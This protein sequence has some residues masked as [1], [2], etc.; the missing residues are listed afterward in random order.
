MEKPRGTAKGKVKE[1]LE[2]E[3]IDNLGRTKEENALIARAASEMKLDHW[4]A[5]Y[6]N[7][8]KNAK[9]DQSNIVLPGCLIYSDPYL[10]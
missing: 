5:N 4:F 1:S 2:E 7:K 3:G 9:R 8:K 6:A 10:C